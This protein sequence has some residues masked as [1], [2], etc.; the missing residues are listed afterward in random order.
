MLLKQSLTTILLSL[1]AFVLSARGHHTVPPPPPLGRCGV[2]PENFQFKSD[3]KLPDPFTFVNGA[4][5]ETKLEFSCRQEEVRQLFQ[6]FEL[7]TLP[8]KPE[9]ITS[10]VSNGNITITVTNEGKS[11]TF[12]PTTPTQPMQQVHSQCIPLPANAASIVLNNNDI[13]LQNDA[14]SRG[15]GKFYDLYGTN[16]TASSMIAW[17]WAIGRIIDVLESTPGHLNVDLT[18]IGVTGCSRNGKGALVAGAFEPRITLTIPQESGSGGA[19]CW[20]ISDSMLSNGTVT[21]TASEIVQENVW[22]S[23]AFDQFVNDTSL[24]PFDHHM[25]AGLVA[26]RALLVIDNTGID[27]LGPESVWGCMKTANT[28]WQALGI[29]DHMGVSQVGNHDH[30]AFPAIEQP[31]LTPFFDKFF[32]NNPSANTTVIKTDGADG[33]GFVDAQWIDW[34]VPRIR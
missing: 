11:I 21:Q 28:V 2:L 32:G 8:P 12:N 6:R 1:P 23:V 5:V 24:L 18:K 33:L 17:T 34:K 30:C 25:L 20:R 27:W 26:P 14:S 22:F 9:K 3:P 10:S 31:D 7:G 16:A 19:G 15:I 29:P 13:A 4:P